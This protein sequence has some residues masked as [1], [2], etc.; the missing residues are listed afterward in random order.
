MFPN[1]IRFTAR[2]AS[3]LLACGVLGTDRA[4]TNDGRNHT[5]CHVNLLT[6]VDNP[7]ACF[8]MTLNGRLEDV[9]VNHFRIQNYFG[10]PIFEGEKIAVS[11]ADTGR[12]PHFFGS[13]YQRCRDDLGI[14]LED[15]GIVSGYNSYRN[16]DFSIKSRTVPGVF[17][18]DIKNHAVL[19]GIAHQSGVTHR[20]GIEASEREPGTIGFERVFGNFC[21]VS[22]NFGG[23]L[24]VVY[25]SAHIPKLNEEH[26]QLEDADQRQDQGSPNNGPLRS[27]PIW[28]RFLEALGLG[29]LGIGGALWCVERF[30]DSRRRL[31]T[32][33]ICCC[34]IM[35]LGALGLFWASLIPGTWGWPI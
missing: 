17:P 10:L 13:K 1:K 23:N 6:V 27:P 26:R 22:G 5:G 2:F 11:N 15:R 16:V 7:Q 33:L 21:G 20:Q 31:S 4:A 34:F 25:A 3:V 32:V 19:H 9:G 18:G 29:G 28:R 30:D 12:S 8:R 35:V 14:M 24:R